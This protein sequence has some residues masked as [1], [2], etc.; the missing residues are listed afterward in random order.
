[1]KIAIDNRKINEH[2]Y[3]PIK[4]YLKKK[5][6]SGPDLAYGLWLTPMLYCLVRTILKPTVEQPP[7]DILCC[8]SP[9]E[10]L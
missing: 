3:E 7:F 5:S 8:L 9:T 10:N 1:M 4:L 2:S 6:G